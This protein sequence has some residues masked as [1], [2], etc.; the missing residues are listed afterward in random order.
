MG[1][2][3][4]YLGGVMSMSSAVAEM[5]TEKDDWATWR[6]GVRAL[7]HG[8]A[9]MDCVPALFKYRGDS[10]HQWSSLRT[11]GNAVHCLLVLEGASAT[12]T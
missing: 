5:H 12:R 2:S 11:K 1:K 7:N 4:G 8:A 9:N 3:C 6:A 10:C